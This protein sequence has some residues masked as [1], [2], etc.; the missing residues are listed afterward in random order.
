MVTKFYLLLLLIG[1]QVVH[2]WA[3]LTMFFA[4]LTNSKRAW[5]VAVSYDQLGN[6]LIGGHE[7]ET[8]SSRAQRA[9]VKGKRWG[10]LL[11]WFLDQL[12]DK[13]CE[14]SLQ[15]ELDTVKSRYQNE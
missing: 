14:R 10:C 1:L 2:I 3:S 4:I 15:I 13:H 7:D 6:V 5:R 11:C 9:L 8:I 12:Q